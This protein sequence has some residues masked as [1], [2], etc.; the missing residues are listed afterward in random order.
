MDGEE[1]KGD[2]PAQARTK[3]YKKVLQKLKKISPF[4]SNEV[5]EINVKNR[6]GR[7]ELREYIEDV[8]PNRNVT[9]E[10]PTETS[11]VIVT[12]AEERT[13]TTNYKKELDALV[14]ILIQEEINGEK[15]INEHNKIRGERKQKILTLNQS[16][17]DINLKSDKI[18]NNIFSET[19]RLLNKNE[20]LSKN[21]PLIEGNRD[22]IMQE[23]LKYTKR[24]KLMVKDN[25]ETFVNDI[26]SF[27]GSK[28]KPKGFKKLVSKI[29][30]SKLS[31]VLYSTTFNAK[32]VLTLI[33]EKY[34]TNT[35]LGQKMKQVFFTDVMSAQNNKKRMEGTLEGLLNDQIDIFARENNIDISHNDDKAKKGL[36]SV[37]D[38]G[39]FTIKQKGENIT[40]SG[41]EAVALFNYSRNPK[42]YKALI[43][44]GFDAEGINT[45]SNSLSQKQRDFADFLVKYHT[46]YQGQ[47]LE[48]SEKLD[49]SPGIVESNYTTLLYKRGSAQHGIIPIEFD[50]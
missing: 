5:G 41:N 38:E 37:I 24:Q 2:T 12:P 14:D 1:I 33:E 49:V 39:E 35:E 43:K 8:L 40:L 30:D 46:Y 13:K 11:S 50:A 32:E 18:I 34:G 29:T 19:E 10:V 3:A 27:L 16:M 26:D 4:V 7:Q 48:L 22:G 31:K 15:I 23:I 28:T 20:E 9:T 6:D 17:N 44:S 45:I 47:V 36:M 25:K 42:A 21:M